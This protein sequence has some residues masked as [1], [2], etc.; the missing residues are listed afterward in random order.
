LKPSHEGTW[1]GNRTSMDPIS[2]PPSYFP[3]PLLC[4]PRPPPSGHSCFPSTNAGAF[5][6]T[7]GSSRR[8]WGG[9]NRPHTDLSRVTGSQSTG[10]PRHTGAPPL[11]VGNRARVPGDATRDHVV[12]ARAQ[13][14]G[15]VVQDASGRRHPVADRRGGR[16][17]PAAQG[18]KHGRAGT[19][20]AVG[21]GD[22][23]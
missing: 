5:P 18:L 20:S 23:I 7:S 11:V 2:S 9:Q 22:I 10:F 12:T 21:L 15:H 6:R 16:R 4:C 3:L 19:A 1:L 8:R 17:R 13:R 14:S